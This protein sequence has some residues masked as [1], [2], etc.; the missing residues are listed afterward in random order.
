MI[1]NIGAHNPLRDRLAVSIAADTILVV[2]TL[3]VLAGYTIVRSER[4]VVPKRPAP[5]HVETA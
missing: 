3:V 5:D 2:P 1:D 4:R